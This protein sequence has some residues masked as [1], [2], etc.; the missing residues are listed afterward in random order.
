[1]THSTNLV[2][3][4]DRRRA[5]VTGASSGIGADT[6]RHL[7]RCGWSV[8]AVARRQDRLDALAAEIGCDVLAA[9]ITSDH[10]V[11]R[12]VAAAGPVH[13]LVNNAGGARGTESIDTA[14][15]NK[16]A[17][18][19]EVNVLG[20]VRLTKA[21]IPALRESGR[22]TIVVVSSLAAETAYAGGGGYCAAKSAERVVAETLRLELNGEPIRV[23]EISPGL[24]HT[25]EF[26]LRRLGGDQAAAD[27]VYAGVPDPLTGDDVAECIAWTL[28]RPHHVNIDRLVV[29]PLAQAA[30]HKLH[31]T[32]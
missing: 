25:E 20:T 27:A 26:S 19:Y 15:L 11:A 16:W 10:D 8:L 5:V 2:P 7:V 29:K 23:V 17:W 24:V 9:D 1:M 32:T 3:S 14:D 18:M 4:S 31:R 30:I 6:A 28:E 21:L 13:A 22:G 12:I